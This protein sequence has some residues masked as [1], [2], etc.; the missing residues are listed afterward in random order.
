MTGRDKEKGELFMKKQS[1]TTRVIACVIAAV[2]YI[3]GFVGTPFNGLTPEGFKAIFTLLAAV[4]LWITEA[5]PVLM[6]CLLLLPAFTYSGVMT[7]KDFFAASSSTAVF[8]TLAGF[9]IGAA[10]LNT[11]FATVIMNTLLKIAKG[12]SKKIIR[13]VL[14]LT[15]VVSLIVANY[16]AIIAVLGLSAAVVKSLGDP[17]PGESK[18]AK[19]IM[20]AVPWGSMCGGVALPCSNGINVVLMNLLEKQTGLEVSFFQWAVVGIPCAIILTLFTAWWLPKYCDPEVLT[21]EQL[22][23]LDTTFGKK[24]TFNGKDWKFLIIVIAMVVLWVCSNW[25]KAFDTT[26]IAILGVG[27]MMLPGID[28]MTGKDYMKSIA[29]MGVIMLLCIMPIA[30]AVSATG[31]GEWIANTIFGGAGSW[32]GF[33]LMLMMA[34]G[35]MVIH[36]LVPSGNSNAALCGVLLF[37]IATALG[38][39]GAAICLILGMMC[40]NNFIAAYEGIYGFTF[41]YGHYTFKDV[42]KCG[43]PIQIVQ[44]ILCVTIVPLFAALT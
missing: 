42:I 26:R 6:T 10:L 3:Y 4:V 40:G 28:I 21:E 25:I 7:P 41:G 36:L 5:I 44:I 19:G 32:S 35:A 34:V 33:T 22:K 24:V 8:F 29:P 1:M 18:L 39:K 11:N 27:L 15:A 16:A 13:G 30:T 23:N 9:G 2:L 20:M 12:D 38:I 17:A 31:A 37:G 43:V 14:I